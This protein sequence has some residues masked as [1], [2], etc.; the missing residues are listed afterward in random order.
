LSNCVLPVD[1]HSELN[2]AWVTRPIIFAEKRSERRRVTGRAQV[3]GDGC[4]TVV[5]EQATWRHQIGTGVDPR[6]LG[7]VEDVKGLNSQLKLAALV[8]I[9]QRNV[10]EDREIRVVDSRISEI[11]AFPL[12]ETAD[13]RNDE[14][15]RVDQETVGASFRVPIKPESRRLGPGSGDPL[16]GI[17]TGDSNTELERIAA[18]NGGDSRKL[19]S[20][21]QPTRQPV[22]PSFGNS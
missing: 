21:E 8:G 7:M 12:T 11:C 6:E 22:V 10:L 19:P 9:A 20:V 18:D 16:V 15:I 2:D 14:R 1:L 13:F 5:V 4:L 3:I 17:D